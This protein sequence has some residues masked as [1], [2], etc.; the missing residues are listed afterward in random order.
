MPNHSGFIY[1][2]RLVAF[3]IYLFTIYNQY[4]FD[5]VPICPY[6]RPKK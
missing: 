5:N 1:R 3:T 4:R 6:F 2:I